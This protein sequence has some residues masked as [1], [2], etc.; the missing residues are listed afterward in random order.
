MTQQSAV[1][2]SRRVAAPVNMR[3]KHDITDPEI[4]KLIGK[5]SVLV[6]KIAHNM[7]RKVAAGVECKDLIQ[8]GLVGLIDAILRWTRE[9]TGAHFDNYVAQRARGAM[10]D[11]LRALDPGTRQIRRDMRRVEVAIQQLGHQLGRSPRDSEVAAAL[12][13]A[14]ADYQQILQDAHGYV[15]ISLEDL[16]GD[17][18]GGL[19]LSN[20]AVTHVDPLVVLERAAFRKRLALAIKALS[21]QKKTL[22]QLYYE[23]G[24]KMHEIGLVLRL[25][26]PRVSQLHTLAIAQL[27]ASLL[28]EQEAAPLL[29]PRRKPRQVAS[30]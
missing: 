24:L 23:E 28:D 4:R 26:V 21:E 15:L 3:H 14:L 6:E 8:D 25:S 19:F 18:D 29:K 13:M 17:E 5:Q 22:L 10:L 20:C 7:V 2:P 1:L 11:G 30:G 16:G 27:R 9:A 12:E